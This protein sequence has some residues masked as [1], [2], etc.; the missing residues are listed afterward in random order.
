MFGIL[1]LA[2]KDSESSSLSDRCNLL[3]FGSLAYFEAE[4]INSK[5]GKIGLGYV[6]RKKQTYVFHF[7]TLLL[8][9][10]Y[11]LSWEGM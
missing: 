11:I 8:P 3:S 10:R 7:Q 6:L 2:G 4:R 1:T 9:Q 5:L